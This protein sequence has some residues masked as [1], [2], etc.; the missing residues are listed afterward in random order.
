VGATPAEA[1]LTDIDFDAGEF[2][3]MP[4]EK[5]SELCVNL[6]ARAKAMADAAPLQEQEHYLLIAREWLRLA[7]GIEAL[8]ECG[9]RD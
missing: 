4:L 5:R 8:V 7:E 2:S 1:P 9:D 3:A 6:A